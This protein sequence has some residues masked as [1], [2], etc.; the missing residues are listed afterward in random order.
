M[1]RNPVNV[2]LRKYEFFFT[3]LKENVTDCSDMTSTDEWSQVN[4]LGLVNLEKSLQ[5]W[6]Y[7]INSILYQE[8]FK[9]CMKASFKACGFCSVNFCNMCENPTDEKINRHLE[10]PDRVT[11]SGVKDSLLLTK[12]VILAI[13]F[14]LNSC[15]LYFRDRTSAS[16]ALQF[17]SFLPSFSCRVER[18]ALQH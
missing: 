6:C 9:L 16:S 15:N 3:V 8:T 10:T 11:N 5:N 4:F 13:H 2:V 14:K 1:R 12:S 18:G 7:D 17:I